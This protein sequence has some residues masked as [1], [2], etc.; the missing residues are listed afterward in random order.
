M[1]I[2][3]EKPRSTPLSEGGGW[4]RGLSYAEH[5]P[6][7]D[8]A[9]WVACV[10]QISGAPEVAP[11]PHRV[12]PDGCADI[13]FN[14]EHARTAGGTPAYLIGPMSRAQVFEMRGPVDVLGVRFRPGA[15]SAFAGVPADRVLDESTPMVELPRALHANVAQLADTPTFAAR[16]AL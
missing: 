14:L 13:L 4:A 11:F 2:R 3:R 6:P 8:L 5:R 10:W 7:P 9:P 16:A 15:M 12:L 1:S